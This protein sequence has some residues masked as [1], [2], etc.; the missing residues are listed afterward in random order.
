MHYDN[1]RIAPI[2]IVGA[3]I[4]Q[5]ALYI[6]SV[7]GPVQAL[8]FAPE[9]VEVCVG[10]GD[11]FPVS[12]RTGPHFRWLVEGVADERDG[13]SISG[14]RQ[15]GRESERFRLGLDGFRTRPESSKLSALRINCSNAATNQPETSVCREQS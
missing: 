7:A 6:H 11:L 12:Y 14:Q 15:R 13:L 2:G 4:Q 8:G 10:V 9:Q 1:H 5:P 3:R